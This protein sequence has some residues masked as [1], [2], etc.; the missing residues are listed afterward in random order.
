MPDSSLQRPANDA[1]RGRPA[2]A[3]PVSAPARRPAEPTSPVTAYDEIWFQGR[4]QL[5]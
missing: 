3:P 1:P 4:P 2:P 5:P